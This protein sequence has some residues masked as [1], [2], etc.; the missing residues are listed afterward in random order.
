M[1]YLI[2]SLIGVAV[3]AGCAGKSGTA[4]AGAPVVVTTE[5]PVQQTKSGVAVETDA[6]QPADAQW[7]IACR[8]FGGPNHVEL[9]KGAKES[10]KAAT[11]M[12]DFYVV[13]ED[14]LST[15]YYGFYRSITPRQESGMSR[16]DVAEGKRAQKDLQRL[17]SMETKFGEKLFPTAFMAPL[18]PVDPPAPAEWD[19]RNVDRNK[20]DNDPTKAFWSLEI[21]IYKDSPERKQ[22]AVDSVRA[23]RE[24]MGVKDAYFYHGK[25]TSSVCIGAWPREAIKEQERR[26]AGVDDPS[27]T[28]ILLPQALPA[29]V[30]D[31][32]HGPDGELIKAIAPRKEIADPT[33]LDYTR[34]YPNRAI[35]GDDIVR[36]VKLKTGGVKKIYEPSQV[37]IIPRDE[38]ILDSPSQRQ[39]ATDPLPL[40]PTRGSGGALRSL[41]Q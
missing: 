24:Q 5:T 17:Q 40:P 23:L 36:E 38:T 2:L 41:G 8:Q 4:P 1:K 37:I 3:V 29:G 19:L 32:V 35:N 12:K 21:A 20:R 25:T 13:H 28:F 14:G 7:S 18:E 33:F 15:L 26:T 6:I 39:L 27:E 30:S 9:A 11:G 31:K 34:R 10:V 22:A 16:D